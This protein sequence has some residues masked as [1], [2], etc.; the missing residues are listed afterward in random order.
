MGH[1][2][3]RRC[4]KFWP[5]L[6]LSLLVAPASV[7]QIEA[8]RQHDDQFIQGL[9][10]AGMPELL[11]RF[12]EQVDEDA[13][14]PVA[15]QQLIIAQR[16]F[17]AT[18]RF[19]RAVE[20]SGVDPAA[21]EALFLESREAYEGLL[22]A[23]EKM[24]TDNPQDERV[25]IWQTDLAAMLLDVY[26]PT[27]FNNAAWFYEFGVGTPEQAEAYE[28]SVVLALELSA[29]ARDR[30]ERLTGR[31]S[32]DGGDLRAK[33]EEMNIY[34]KLRQDYG[35]RRTPYWFAHSAY[36]VAL[37]PQS[38]AYYQTVGNN[39]NVPHQGNTAELERTRLLE[40]A[41]IIGTGSLLNDPE[42]GTS[43]RLLAGRAMVGYGSVDRADE[44]VDGY[45]EAV[46][47]GS[48]DTWQG[49]LASLGKARGRAV[50]G[51]V[52]TAMDILSG[53]D[54]HTFVSQ[55]LNNGNMYPRLI[56]AD[57]MHRML[58]APAEQAR[59]EDRRLLLADAY[60]QPYMALINDD[61]ADQF[62]P[63]LYRR[64]SQ[65]V[66]PGEDPVSLPPMVRMG[67]GQIKTGQGGGLANQLV[68]LAQNDPLTN[69]PIP[70]DRDRESQRRAEMKAQAEAELARGAAFN[71]TLVGEETEPPLRATALMN[72]GFC[73][74]YLAEL[75]KYYD[76]EQ[77]IDPYF[78]AAQL[79]A[80]I[81]VEL[82][83][84][85]QAEQA[86]QYAVT[87]LQQF[88][89]LSNTGPEGVT[90]TEQR[91][92][93]R[94][95]IDVMYE[96]WPRN[97]TAHALRVYTGFF[98]YELS[99]D[100]DDAIEVYRGMPSEH[101]DYFEARRQMILAMQKVYDTLS[102]E[103]RQMELTGATGDNPDA[104]Q[105]HERG[106]AQR[107]EDLARMRRELLETAERLEFTA[108]D[109][110]EQAE[111]P[112][113]RFSAATARGG[114]L[115]AIAAME[116]DEGDA[117]RALD[118]LEG[119]ENDFTPN[120]QLAPLIEQQPDPVKAQQQLDGLIQSAQE[121]RILSLVQAD[122]L[123]RIGPE[124]QAMIR[125]YPDVAAGVVNGVLQRIED[126]IEVFQAARAKAV[127]PVNRAEADQNIARLAGVAVQ[128]SEL[129]VTWAADQGYTGNRLLPF[130]TGL[131]RA[132]LLSDRAPD[133]L[134]IMNRWLE[135]FPNNFDVV[136]LTADCA[137]GAARANNS[138]TPNDINPALDG[139]KKI[140]TYYNA[141]P[142][143]KPAR[144]WEAW[145][146]SLL[147]LDYV[148][149]EAAGP[150]G[151]RIRM[152]QNR[153][154]PELGG[155]D[156]KPKFMELYARHLR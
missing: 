23:Q 88:D 83:D 129:L 141:Q 64:W 48:A 101:P 67:I 4:W 132:L 57:L 29:S 138:R 27:Y 98:V 66:G 42:V 58:L 82:P 128:L 92:A 143:E 2:A 106:L 110:Y 124:A 11:G 113:R 146:K 107:A 87:L 6:A 33:L 100:L 17:A 21:A 30:I 145:L 139:Y 148:G 35:Q 5:T 74:Y 93:Y 59:G 69:Y 36:Y 3:S 115:V 135:E 32:S 39:P 7:G 142:G 56:A 90:N 152:L 72:L 96:Y 144:F 153:V 134:S 37:L 102:D 77:S 16:E 49:F 126:Q 108:L 34:F 84:T 104:Q 70:A 137:L 80:T 10:E 86:T 45:L 40:Q 147:T 105:I 103:R 68:F 51:E 73:K 78:A 116:S 44:G 22:A 125:A 154:D 130:E 151:D 91:D 120:G 75:A 18:E 47:T 127:L 89:Q 118:L 62:A 46:I 8:L 85:A 38:H 123:D 13:L 71:E 76:G 121:R 26:L 109:E 133:A 12:V 43:M 52:D 140:I 97:D 131:A 95:A 53:M 9:R 63:F 79:W 61:P 54:K 114:A 150:I 1:A 117:D 81:G 99:G 65:Q 111:D 136:M 122:D 156:F 20:A 149:G 50:A 155:P 25:P 94:R 14:D 15:R 28:R 112:R 41:E 24:I 55:Q 60:E 19:Q 119:F 31:L